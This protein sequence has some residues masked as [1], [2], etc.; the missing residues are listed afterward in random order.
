[1]HDLS[2]ST[3][4][5][6]LLLTL[7]AQVMNQEVNAF[8]YR[9]EERVVLGKPCVEAMSGTLD[10]TKLARY[11]LFL[12]YS[13]GLL[14]KLSIDHYI[15]SSLHQ[16]GWGE[17]GLFEE[18]LWINFVVVFFRND[19]IE[20]HALSHGCDKVCAARST[21]VWPIWS[22]W[23]WSGCRRGHLF[24]YLLYEFGRW[25]G[26]STWDCGVVKSITE[27]LETKEVKNSFRRVG[28]RSLV[29]S[30]QYRSRRSLPGIC[31]YHQ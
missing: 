11:A 22:K 13:I 10:K 5:E 28:T 9:L 19:I 4:L 3:P 7:F 12:E 8:L 30:C 6:A 14:R 24:E 27:V 31:T 29:R 21:Q 17:S 2:I 18:G 20:L 15:C 1:M 23:R 16:E 25:A 26:W